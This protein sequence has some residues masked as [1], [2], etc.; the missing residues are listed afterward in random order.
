MLDTRAN[1]DSKVSELR[2]FA[3]EVLDNL[4]TGDIKQIVL[5]LLDDLTV[6]ERLEHLFSK[7]PQDKLAPDERFDEIMETHFDNAFYWTKSCL[8]YV[9]GQQQANKHIEKVLNSLGDEEPIARETSAWSIAQL[10]PPDLRRTLL[11]H[12]G[13]QHP[14]V[15]N[16]VLELLEDLPAPD[17]VP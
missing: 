4:L 10:N 9:I 11:A 13:D 6:A 7:F 14:A 17:P 5:P 2:T 3:L 1:I 8:L 15:K 12:A 16:I